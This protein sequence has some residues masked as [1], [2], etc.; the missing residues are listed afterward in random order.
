[1]AILVGDLGGFMYQE[2]AGA[3]P[4][5]PKM[6]RRAAQLGPKQMLNSKILEDLKS[7]APKRK[8]L[9]AQPERTPQNACTNNKPTLTCRPSLL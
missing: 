5:S 6:N 8:C 1:M 3:K 7:M 4:E 9:S 2:E